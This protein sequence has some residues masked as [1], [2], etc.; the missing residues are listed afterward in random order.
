[1]IK[2][3][4]YLAIDSAWGSTVNLFNSGF[5][6]E[7]V[8]V[9]LR[10]GQRKEERNLIL[11]PN[12]RYVFDETLINSILGVSPEPF[13]VSIMARISIQVLTGMY[14]KDS[15][16][17]K[18]FNIMPESNITSNP[19]GLY[20][21]NGLAFDM[22]LN[23]FSYIYCGNSFGKHL[24]YRAGCI[25]DFVLSED[26]LNNTHPIVLG[27]CCRNDTLDVEGHPIGSHRGIEA[28]GG[29]SFDVNYPRHDGGYT[30]YRPIG[31]N[32]SPIFNENGELL[33][34]FFDHRRFYLLLM[35]LRSRFPNM[36][37]RTDQRI[38]NFMNVNY[39]PISW[40]QCDAPNEYQ[41]NSHC[42]IDLGRV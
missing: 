26:F 17:I 1:M 15:S 16:G 28:D 35:A 3:Y 23:G 31:I 8:K 21:G 40:L 30:Q 27:D 6:P 34:N 14:M 19:E 33:I 10:R 25:V 39:A 12:G 42:H 24:S 5:C 22:A 4:P 41:H 9:S 13:S 7:K 29:F 37:A 11:Q 32:A 38:K 20:S 2:H 36:S 18:F